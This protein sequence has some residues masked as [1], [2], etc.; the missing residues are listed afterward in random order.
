ML[1]AALVGTAIA[2]W[3]YFAPMTGIDGTAG[4]LLVVVSSLLLVLDGVILLFLPSGAVRTIMLTL[5]V[6]GALGT[7]AAAG[8]L[9]AWWLMAAMVVVALGLAADIFMKHSSP[10]PRTS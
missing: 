6:L 4:A 7:F 1:A 3:G 5:G 8:F 9:H 10:A 2:L